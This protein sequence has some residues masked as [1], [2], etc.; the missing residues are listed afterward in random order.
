MR[1]KLLS[2]QTVCFHSVL[3][4]F[5]MSVLLISNSEMTSTP[6]PMTAVKEIGL[7]EKIPYEIK[8]IEWRIGDFFAVTEEEKCYRYDSPTFSIAN[9]LWHLRLLPNL[10]EK[11]ESIDLYLCSNVKREYSVEYYFGLK[12]YDDEV[13]QLA[14]GILK[15]NEAHNVWGHFIKKTELLQWKSVLVPCS[16]LT[17]TCT[18]KFMTEVSHS[19]QQTVLHETSPLKLISKL[20]LM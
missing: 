3:F 13:E 12:R 4:I 8:Q 15:G 9:I 1:E 18:L 6:L 19:T 10:G 11:T 2:V 17:I 7:V 14:S 5:R 16:V 20:F